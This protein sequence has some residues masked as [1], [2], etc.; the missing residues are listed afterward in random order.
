ML[1]GTIA[2]VA[3]S[4]GHREIIRNGETGFLVPPDDAQAFAER[5]CQLLARPDEVAALA[6]RARTEALD[7][8]GTRRHVQSVIKVYESLLSADRTP[9]GSSSSA[10]HGRRGRRAAPGS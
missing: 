6:R 7:R 4:G 9:A 3:D 1:V 2:I 8:F 10:H 5:A